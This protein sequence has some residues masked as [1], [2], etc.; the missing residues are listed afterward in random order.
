MIEKGF[1]DIGDALKEIKEIK[2]G[3]DKRM[4]LTTLPEFARS[5][6]IVDGE[7]TE[8]IAGRDLGAMVSMLTVAVQQLA[9]RLDALENPGL[10]TK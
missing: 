10:E 4:D 3:V 8:A 9:T 5:Y 2:S 7:Q 1:G 6:K